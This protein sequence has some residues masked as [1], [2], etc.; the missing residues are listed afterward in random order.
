MNPTYRYLFGMQLRA[1]REERGLQQKVVAASLRISPST[2]SNY[3][4]GIYSPNLDT[5]IQIADLFD[6]SL[7]R[8]VGRDGDSV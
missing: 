5:L 3:E 6:I 7:D 8:L 4:N 1:L 2:Y